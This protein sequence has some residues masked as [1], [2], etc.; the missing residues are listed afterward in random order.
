VIEDNADDAELIRR[1]FR[2]V[3]S[4]RALVCR[5]LSEGRA[6]IQGAGMNRDRREYPFPNA[7]IC[8]LR[9]G[10]ESGV[11]FVAWLK[12]IPEYCKVPIIVL[13]SSASDK[14]LIGAKNSGASDVLR[15]PAR[16]EESQ[17]LLTD[18]TRKL[19]S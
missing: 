1:A 2:A 8:D 19:S 15:K 7:V 11:E 14:E 16:F 18:L 12:S 9:L 10:G 3:E 13:S 17:A 4:C 6:Y 5:N